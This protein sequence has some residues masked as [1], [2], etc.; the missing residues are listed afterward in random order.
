MNEFHAFE[1]Y[2]DASHFVPMFPP[3]ICNNIKRN[4]IPRFSFVSYSVLRVKLSHP[5][6]SQTARKFLQS[7]VKF[8]SS[9]P[10]SVNVLRSY[11]AT[12]GTVYHPS[13]LIDS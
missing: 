13:T 8:S 1:R 6:I 7:L 4:F 2:V 10:C 12:H 11:Y 9:P 5:V 3:G